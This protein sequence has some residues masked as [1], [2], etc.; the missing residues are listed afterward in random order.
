MIID[1]IIGKKNMI[2]NNKSNKSDSKY[3]N[4]EQFL[5]ISNYTDY[6]KNIIEQVDKK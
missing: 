1:T 5:D 6:C 3:F 4:I 2:K